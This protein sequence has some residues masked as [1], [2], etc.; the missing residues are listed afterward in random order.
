VILSGCSMRL[1]ALS[2]RVAAWCSIAGEAVKS[3]VM[4]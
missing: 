3:M 4:S 2:I 1:W